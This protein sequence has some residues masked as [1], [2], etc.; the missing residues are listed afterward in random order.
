MVSTRVKNNR[1]TKQTII[2]INFFNKDSILAAQNDR[3]STVISLLQKNSEQELSSVENVSN[4]GEKPPPVPFHFSIIQTPDDTQEKK[5]MGKFKKFC[6]VCCFNF[7]R[8]SY[9][10]KELTI[11]DR[12]MYRDDVFYGN[13]L[14]NLKHSHS[15]GLQYH[16]SVTRVPDPREIEEHMQRKFC[17]CQAVTRTI[18]TMLGLNLL[19]SKIFLFLCIS[20]F[21]YT[22]GL[23]VPYV[24][25]KSKQ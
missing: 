14:S 6:N 12:P 17:G 20:S 13:S 9:K 11:G 3:R 22:M 18:V 15:E 4:L 19:K 5:K 2:S 25:V 16:M 7:W 1:T 10:Q 24:F 8:C 21:F 23:Y